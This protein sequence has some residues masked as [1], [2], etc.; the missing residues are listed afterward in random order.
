M[1]KRLLKSLVLYLDEFF[2]FC[3]A[4]LSSFWFW[5][6]P[7]FFVSLYISLWMMFVIHP[8]SILTSPSIVLLYIIY[9]K[10]KRD[11]RKYE[12]TMDIRE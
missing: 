11:K 7:I 8:L 5:L 9:V 6:A 2:L 3:K 10:E 4:I 1:L 12:L